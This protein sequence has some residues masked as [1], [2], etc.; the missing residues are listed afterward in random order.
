MSAKLLTPALFCLGMVPFAA[1]PADIE[2]VDA[3]IAIEVLAVDPA[4]TTGTIPLRPGLT[5]SWPRI[6]LQPARAARGAVLEK[7]GDVLMLALLEPVA[8]TADGKAR[9]DGPADRIAW[10]ASAKFISN[11]VAC[12]QDLDS[13]GRFETRR[14]GMLGTNEAL[15]LSR[16]QMPK[17]IAPLAYRPANEDELPAFQVGYAACGGTRHDTQT[18]ESP[19][20]YATVIRRAEGAQWP[21]SGRCD[22][23]AKFIDM[24]PDGARLY[25]LGRFKIE[26]REKDDQELAT[27]LVEGMA[28]GTLLAHVRSSW[29]LTDATERPREADALADRNSF[30]VAVGK[31]TVATLAKPGDQIF[32][33]EVRHALTAHLSAPSEPSV[34]GDKVRLPEGTPLYGIAM[35]SSLTPWADG[36]VIWC[37]PVKQEKTVE[38]YCFAPS[39]YGGTGLYKAHSKP[40]TVTGVSPSGPVRNPPVVEPAPV[41]FGAPLVLAVKVVSADKKGIHLNWSLAPRGQWYSEEWRFLHARDKSS[42]LLIGRLVIQIKPSADGQSF[43][44]STRGDEIV[45]GAPVD[46]PADAVRL[47]R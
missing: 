36:L 21:K 27:L 32:S 6:A 16:L 18:F 47:L 42:F 8:K 4:L 19:P 41:D 22:N 20:R 17:S 14:T 45:D 43:E 10:C 11:V 37:T 34:K 31:P 12:Y 29:P 1:A 25:E 23:I 30:L 39:Q 26:V 38:P 35:Q 7:N 13:D 44:I 9:I 40:F 15:A 46:L 2:T 24:R 33:L 5:W 28:P 3:T